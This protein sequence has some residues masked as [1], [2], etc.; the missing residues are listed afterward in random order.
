MATKKRNRTKPTGEA[1]GPGFIEPHVLYRL[2]E[3][4]R[5]MGW[6]DGAIREARR[7]GLNVLY[8]GKRAYL[9]GRDLIDDIETSGRHSNAQETPRGR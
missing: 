5:R 9:L 6:G 1:T 8:A 7:N 2:E 3:A 4:K